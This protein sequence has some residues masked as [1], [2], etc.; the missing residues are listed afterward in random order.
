MDQPPTKCLKIEPKISSSLS[1]NKNFWNHGKSPILVSFHRGKFKLLTETLQNY[2]T[3]LAPGF[4]LR[5]RRRRV[6]VSKLRYFDIFGSVC[7]I[8]RCFQIHN[9]Y[10]GYN[11]QCFTFAFALSLHFHTLAMPKNISNFKMFYSSVSIADKYQ[12]PSLKIREHI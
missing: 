7:Q 4:F 5:R 8:L 2:R 9:P 3:T 12:Q 6:S 1:E 10:F 11:P